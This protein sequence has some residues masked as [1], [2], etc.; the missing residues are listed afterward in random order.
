MT[1]PRTINFTPIITHH[2]V[3][4]GQIV[5]KI[6]TNTRERWRQQNVSGA[7]A[8][9]RKLVPTHPPDKKLSK[10]EILRMAIRYIRLLSNVLDWQQTQEEYFHNNPP[11]DKNF[12][13]QTISCIKYSIIT[14]K[15]DITKN[16]RINYLHNVSKSFNDITTFE[17]NNGNN[18]LMVVPR[19]I[20]PTFQPK[21]LLSAI[22]SEAQEE[23]NSE[24]GKING[25]VQPLSSL[26]GIKV[27]GLPLNNNNNNNFLSDIKREP[28]HVHP[29]P[30]H[31]ILG[32]Y[33]SAVIVDQ[34]KVN[35]EICAF[36]NNQNNVNGHQQMSEN[37]KGNKKRKGGSKN[38]PNIDDK[39]R[40]F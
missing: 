28:I 11:N 2:R 23:T 40:K 3:R 38:E 35:D 20:K 39:R 25:E 16:N 29:Q 7:F 17:K 30:H 10:N 8:E 1:S 9:L 12:T 36:K 24:C 14:S 31:P 13:N 18:L 32:N 21:F 4:N 33:Q 15:Y 37:R 34:Q 26:K 5:R 22:K 27:H 19:N 6:F